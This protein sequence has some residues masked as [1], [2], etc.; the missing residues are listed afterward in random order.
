MNINDLLL[1]KEELPILHDS[2]FQIPVHPKLLDSTINIRPEIA[3]EIFLQ[4]AEEWHNDLKGYLPLERDLEKRKWYEEVFLKDKIK[5]TNSFNNQVLND[6]WEDNIQLLD[7]GLVSG[8]SIS[9][10]AGGSLY[11]NLEGDNFETL[12]PTPYIKFSEEKIKE[13]TYKKIENHCLA[14]VYKQHNIDHFPGALFLRN[15]AI[16]YMNNVFREIF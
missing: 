8:F 3:K 9:R 2:C 5:I 7:N 1:K 10:N 6:F 13:F 16:S 11:F 12:I 4:V 14:L 15:W